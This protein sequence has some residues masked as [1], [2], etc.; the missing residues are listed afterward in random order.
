M[1]FVKEVKTTAYFSRYQV[2]YRRRREGKTDYYARKRLVVQAKNKY[3]APKYRLVVRFS[4][5]NITVQVVYA[6]LQGDFV[7]V[8]AN[9]RELPRYGIEHGL[10]NWTAAYATGLLAARRALT[11]LGLADKYQGVAEP[12]GTISLTE[13]I[14]GAPRPFKAYLD[15]GLKRTSTG[16][17]VFGALKGASDGGIFIPHSEKRFPGYDTE[18]KTLDAEVLKKYIFGGHVAEYMESLEEE[19][20]ERFKK[21]FASY[22][23]SGVGSEDIE[24][25][26]TNAYAAIREDPTFKPTDKGDKNWKEE[27]LKH[28]S[29]RL[30]LEQ[31]K[32]NIQQKI[33]AFK[34]GQ[35]A[36]AE[37]DE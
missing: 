1:P 15:V 21:Q 2:K 31:R 32:V 22:L 9:S 17:R 8:A 33:E 4:N 5:K 18:S 12:D 35:E 25:I 10:T 28:M 26:Y 6:R 30:T 37:D 13:A 34:A 19:D 36:G 14:E 20:D 23:E 27:T 7:L 29:K 24:E 3:N 16:S 11:K